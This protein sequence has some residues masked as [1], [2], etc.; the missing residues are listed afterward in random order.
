MALCIACLAPTLAWAQT[1]RPAPAPN[2]HWSPDACGDC[3]Q[4]SGEKLLPIAP[5]TVTTLCISCHD[6]QRASEEVHP[7]SSKM[8]GR[9]GPNPG[10]PTLSGVLYCQTCHDTRQ[11]CDP[12]AQ[13]PIINAAFLRQ[14]MAPAAGATTAPTTGP[15][16]A[17]AA[18]DD[19]DPIPF[20]DNC[21][22]PDQTPK[23]SPHLMLAADQHTVIE[24]RC[25]VC[26]QKPMDRNATARTGDAFLRA[27]QVTLCRSCHPHHRDISRTG[28]VGTV[29]QP[30]MLV[31]M[32][33][34]ELTGLINAP[35]NDL[36]AQLKA[37]NAR[38]TLMVPDPTGRIVCTTCH[39]PHEQGVFSP[40]CALADRALHPVQGHLLTP[41]RGQTFCRRCHSF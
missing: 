18:A 8:S 3:H 20:C 9:T 32:R 30:D 24:Q 26:H 28:H 12:A 19:G 1:T 29:I 14:T 36:T 6:G 27:D 16:V 33:A 17:A 11:Q 38:P 21:H 7:I 39:N 13:R 15:A 41:V 10:W 4:R 37:A 25:Q 40:G 35:S 23:F 31:Y 22:A 34:R 2:P 5:E